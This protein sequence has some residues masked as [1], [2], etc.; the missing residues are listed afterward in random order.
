MQDRIL[1]DRKQT[2]GL[3]GMAA[4]MAAGGT[5]AAPNSAEALFGGGREAGLELKH[6]RP[7]EMRIGEEVEF[8]GGVN[9]LKRFDQRMGEVEED[10]GEGEDDDEEDAVISEGKGVKN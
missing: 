1:T 10:E 2:G 5:G 6:E 8:T 4:K 7:V 3:A 9:Y